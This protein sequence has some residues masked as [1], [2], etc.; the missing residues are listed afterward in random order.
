M[1]VII[2]LLLIINVARPQHDERTTPTERS[3]TVAV[4]AG[5]GLHIV[6]SENIVEFINS[7]ASF[8]QRV[9]DYTSAVDFFGG[10]EIPVSEFWGV[11]IE[12]GLMFKSYAFSGS[13]GGMHDVYYSIRS[14]SVIVQRVVTGK[15]Y[16]FKVGAGGGYRLGMLSRK[17]STFG[18]EDVYTSNGWGVKAEAAGQT[19]FGE[20]M[21][22]YISA[23]LGYD[24][25]GRLRDDKGNHLTATAASEP[26]SI[27]TISA[28]IRFGLIHYF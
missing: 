4:A 17:I 23:S 18:T 22:G 13:G 9:E 12:H 20:N 5:M 15:G 24:H 8:S 11:K 27:R 19:A 26:V 3:N 21:F 10:V 2:F 16:F 6:R 14:T 1:K 7:T 28:G 25:G